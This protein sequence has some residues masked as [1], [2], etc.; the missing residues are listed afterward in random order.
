M[1]RKLRRKLPKCLE[2][3]GDDY[4]AKEVRYGEELQKIGGDCYCVD[5]VINVA[6]DKK[7]IGEC[8]ELYGD[9]YRAK[10]WQVW[11]GTAVR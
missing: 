11:R 1:I 3:Y 4:R 8:L 7:K 9:H 2:L 5:G 10:E 6:E